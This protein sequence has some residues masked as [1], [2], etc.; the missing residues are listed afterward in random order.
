MTQVHRQQSNARMSKIVRHA[1]TV[2]LCG[3]TASG[4]DAKG[5]E[6]QTR[7]VLRRVDSL[8]ADAGTDKSRILSAL[9]HLVDMKDFAAMNSVWEGWVPAG[10][11]PARTTV[12]AH[13]ASESLRIEVT[14]TAAA[15]AAAAAE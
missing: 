1:G 5:I 8:L 10:C 3:Q 4:S 7:E 12:Q 13:L 14:V 2:Y 9:I 6:E 15:A 11:A